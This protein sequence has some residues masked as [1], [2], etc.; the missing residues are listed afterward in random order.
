MPIVAQARL[1]YAMALAGL[2]RYQEARAQL[3]EGVKIFS[4]PAGI[5]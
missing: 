1:G 5:R 4:Q 2:S 3:L